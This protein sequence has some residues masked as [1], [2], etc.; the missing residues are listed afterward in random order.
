MTF[1]EAFDI[2]DNE[3]TTL[4]EQIIQK[5]KDEKMDS[6]DLSN[7][8]ERLGESKLDTLSETQ[9]TLL[10]S[11]GFKRGSIIYTYNRNKKGLNKICNIKYSSSYLALTQESYKYMSDYE[12]NQHKKVTAITNTKNIINFRMDGFSL[13]IFKNSIKKPFSGVKA[14][15][16]VKS[17]NKGFKESS[18]EFEQIS[19][20]NQFY[21]LILDNTP[22]HTK[23][24]INELEET[25]CIRFGSG[26]YYIPKETEVVVLESPIKKYQSISTEESLDTYS[27]DLNIVYNI[28]LELDNRNKNRYLSTASAFI[29]LYL[30][31]NC[32]HY[33][34]MAKG[35]LKLS[36]DI[37]ENDQEDML[38]SSTLTLE[39]LQNIK[40]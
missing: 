19:I 28:N 22:K 25:N 40:E 3:D 35:L 15:Q 31:T 36:K 10:V 24:L 37:L 12:I 9:Q 33:K 21:K 38:K 17:V 16:L 8:L 11:M 1:S 7:Y 27:T 6:Y 5:T 30:R 13:N 18:K 34:T 14:R 39:L 32:E 20:R 26:I 2:I 29:T 4:Y 23:A